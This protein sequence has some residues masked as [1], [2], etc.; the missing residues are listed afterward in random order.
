MSSH[1]EVQLRK[2]LARSLGGAPFVEDFRRSNTE[3]LRDRSDGLRQ[4]RGLANE[5]V[6]RGPTDSCL[7]K[8]LSEAET[9]RPAE[10]LD[11]FSGEAHEMSVLLFSTHDKKALCARIGGVEETPNV[12]GYNQRVGEH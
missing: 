5:V 1:D 6:V 3:R 9:C 10:A 8:Q 12:F 2:E 7:R 4:D 11:P